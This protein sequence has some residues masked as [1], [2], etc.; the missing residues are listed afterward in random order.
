MNIIPRISDK[1]IEIRGGFFQCWG[2]HHCRASWRGSCRSRHAGRR[3]AGGDPRGWG[4]FN[5]PPTAKNL[6][7]FKRNRRFLPVKIWFLVVWNS[8]DYFSF[9]LSHMLSPGIVHFFPRSSV[10][11]FTNS[12]SFT[13]SIVEPFELLW[14]WPFCWRFSSSKA[15]RW[16]WP[17]PAGPAVLVARCHGPRGPRA[18]RRWAQ[19]RNGPWSFWRK[20]CHPGMWST[21]VPWNL[22]SELSWGA[23]RCYF[24]FF[25]DISPF[26]PICLWIV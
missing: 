14:P 24:L 20:T 18:V 23:V 10:L 26:D 5:Q 8:Q 21:R 1:S 19:P 2:L 9:H 16:R 6:W 25:S 7:G 17:G 4:C 11:S 3:F 15:L 13:F 12:I 22:E